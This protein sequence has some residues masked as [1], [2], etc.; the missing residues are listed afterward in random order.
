MDD[1]FP[2]AGKQSVALIT[3]EAGV[4][5]GRVI[6]KIG[7]IDEFHATHFTCEPKDCMM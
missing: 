6:L 4:V 2:F 7:P 1:Q 5:R 3:A